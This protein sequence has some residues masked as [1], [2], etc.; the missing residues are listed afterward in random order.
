MVEMLFV[1]RYLDIF[2]HSSLRKS[3]GIPDS[4]V[5]LQPWSNYNDYGWNLAPTVILVMLSIPVDF[6]GLSLFM[7]SKTSSSLIVNEDKTLD[8]APKAPYM[9]FVYTRE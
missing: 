7:A 2:N 9:L 6:L 5:Q 1:D 3:L 4:R 8:G